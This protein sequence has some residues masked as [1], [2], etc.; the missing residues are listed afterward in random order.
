[1]E[2]NNRLQGYNYDAAGNMLNDGSYSYTYNAE[3]QMATGA[4]V[5]YIGV[6]PER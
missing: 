5:T 2:T 3:G 1:M 6:Y 4:G